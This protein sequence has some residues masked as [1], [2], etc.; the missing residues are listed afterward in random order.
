MNHKQLILIGVFSLLLAACSGDNNDLTQYIHR[1]KHR[2]TRAIEPIPVFKPLPPFKFPENEARR[3]PFKP[4]SAKK[5]VDPYAPDQ[6]RLREPL[7]AYPLDSLKFVGTLTED[8]KVWALIKEPDSQIIRVQIGNYMGQNYGR[9]AVIK[10]NALKLEETIKGSSGQ[11]EK[12]M[13]T[14]E[15]YTGT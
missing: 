5:H 11:W 15:L 10:N 3:N 6:H 4:M 13:T 7:E 1:V 8:N 14:L 12:H 9:I 2:K